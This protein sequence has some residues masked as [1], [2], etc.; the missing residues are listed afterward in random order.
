[1]FVERVALENRIKEKVGGVPS[2]MPAFQ[3][4]RLV[5]AL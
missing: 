4:R 5:S 2:T 3:L 1:M